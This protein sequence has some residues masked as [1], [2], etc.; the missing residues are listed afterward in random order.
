MPENLTDKQ[1]KNR[2]DALQILHKNKLITDVVHKQDMPHHDLVE[3]LVRKQNL[4]KLNQVL[5]QMEVIEIARFLE[6]LPPEDQLF[7]W[8]RLGE[9]R[10][11]QVLRDIPLSV[12][13][14]LGQSEYKNER[15]SVKAFEL[16]DGRL[17][18][19]SINAREDLSGAKPIWV[20][21]VAPA[22]EE[23]IWVGDIFGIDFRPRQAG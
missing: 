23:R 4:V 9:D 1:Q 22:F 11:E 6:S 3:T 10:K 2:Q 7:I 8:A 5:G 21:L 15:S 16:A 17:R 13:Q 20:D 14:V 19:I 12:L 18:E